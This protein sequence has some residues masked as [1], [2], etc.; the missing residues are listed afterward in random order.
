MRCA[1]SAPHVDT[2]DAASERARESEKGGRAREATPA[3]RCHKARTCVPT[4]E[5]GP[6][7]SRDVTAL[8]S[9][10]LQPLLHPPLIPLPTVY[11]SPGLPVLA[12]LQSPMQRSRRRYCSRRSYPA[13]QF[14]GGRQKSRHL[15]LLYVDLIKIPF[16]SGRSL[17]GTTLKKYE[18]GI[19]FLVLSPTCLPTPSLP[20]PVSRRD[21]RWTFNGSAPDVKILHS[22]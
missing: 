8:R 11:A 9:A 18:I 14:P 21:T 5:G 15:D 10:R 1:A 20:C 17:C 2:A 22:F 7:Q 19:C 12:V 16:L 3:N 6:G 4:R 13:D